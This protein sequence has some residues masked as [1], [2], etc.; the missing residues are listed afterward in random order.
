MAAIDFLKSPI[1]N[2]RTKHIDVKMFFVRDLLNQEIFE[3][4][5]I[6]SK[7]NLADMFTKPLT[8]HDLYK[9]VEAIFKLK[10]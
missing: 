6:K 8:K 5:Y 10:S 7:A 2:Y 3:V 4:N 9:F 1:E